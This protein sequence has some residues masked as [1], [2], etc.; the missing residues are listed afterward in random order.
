MPY[1]ITQPCIGERDASC[2]DAC[3]VDAIHPGPSDPDFGR[4][5]QLYIN[6]AECIDCGACEPACPHEAIVDASLV[7][8]Q[9]ER[10]IRIN[11]EFFG[12]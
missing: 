3:P 8:A 7:P 5:E 4:H 1:I 11:A 10:F 9:W 12:A 6:P 2:Y